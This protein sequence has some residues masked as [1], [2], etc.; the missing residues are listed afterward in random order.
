MDERS[1]SR[2][3]GI[4]RVNCIS[5]SQKKRIDQIRRRNSVSS[6]LAGATK[7]RL[8]LFRTFARTQTHSRGSQR[9]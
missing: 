5:L 2:A 7:L 1:E 4:L 6:G 8:G 9:G 3:S